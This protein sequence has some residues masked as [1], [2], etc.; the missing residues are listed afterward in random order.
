[1]MKIKFIKEFRPWGIKSDMIK[2][3][4]GSK[5]KIE[6]LQVFSPLSI[7]VHPLDYHEIYYFETEGE[8]YL[9]FNDKKVLPD[10]IADCKEKVLPN[11]YLN[12][13]IAKKGDIFYIKGGIVHCLLKGTIIEII[14]PNFQCSFCNMCHSCQTY[15][16]YDWGRNRKLHLNKAYKILNNLK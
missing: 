4:K 16:L 6:V 15:R 13:I 8:L 12:K 1:M 9:G 3:F 11:K 5:M 10:F 7:H 14:S 2:C